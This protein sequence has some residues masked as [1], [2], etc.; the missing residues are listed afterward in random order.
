M[1]TNNVVITNR[2]AIFLA[3]LIVLLIRILLCS[4]RG[5]CFANPYLNRFFQ[6]VDYI[7]ISIGLRYIYYRLGW[8]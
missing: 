1:K 5:D 6:F 2:A 4:I 8:M 7:L 3:S